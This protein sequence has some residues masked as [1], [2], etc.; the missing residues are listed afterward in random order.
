M[1]W[2]QLENFKVAANTQN[3]SRAARLMSVSQPA[4]SRSISKLEQELGCPLF[5]R[6]GKHV[7]L[8][9]YGRTFLQ[10]VEQALQEV[11]TGKKVIQDM[12]HPDHGTVSLAFLHSLGGNVVPRLLGKFHNR[13]P[14]IQFKLYQNYTTLLIDQL[15]AGEIDLCLC[16]PTIDKPTLEWR[17]LFNEEL[18]IAVPHG[19]P[20]AHRR[21][22]KLTEIANEP[23]VTFKQDY[24]L[25]IIMDQFFHAAGVTPLI[26]F[27]G[28]EILTVAGL[29]EARFGI[30][31]IPRI[32]GLEN[33]KISFLH[34]AQAD[35][36]RMIEMV[37]VRNRYL[38]PAAHTF[39]NFVIN[40]FT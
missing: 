29:V 3:I 24:G 6:N 4:L 27:E 32:A 35:C 30:A 16:S 1:E 28:E 8:N 2:Y 14:D 21:E 37:W 36:S 9:R 10:Y 39:R 20:L 34:I 40:E 5:E 38:S 19:H 12:L 26:A 18:L 15:E 13:Y 11:D 17:P 22:I 23:V 33:M 25:R 7:I 31:L